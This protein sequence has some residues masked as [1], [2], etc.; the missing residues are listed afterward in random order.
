MRPPPPP[1]RYTESEKIEIKNIRDFF[2]WGGGGEGGQEAKETGEEY[3]PR[4][5]LLTGLAS[6]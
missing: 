2:F 1:C 5:V 4:V 6:R 3:K